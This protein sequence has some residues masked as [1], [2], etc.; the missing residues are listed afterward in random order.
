MARARGPS[1]LLN[2]AFNSL[3]IEW[4]FGVSSSISTV[5]HFICG[6][7]TRPFRG[8]IYLCGDDE[9]KNSSWAAGRWLRFE[10]IG[11]VS[12]SFGRLN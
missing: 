3:H 11:F 5:F 6:A 1:W 9:Q 12:V 7:N 8:L 10:K 2:G 4:R